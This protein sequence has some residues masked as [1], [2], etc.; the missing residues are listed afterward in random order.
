[1]STLIKYS[2]FKSMKQNSIKSKS[3][4]NAQKKA[5]AEMLAFL[6]LLSKAKEKKA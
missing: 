3:I 2:N 1:M 4:A 6:R 5:E